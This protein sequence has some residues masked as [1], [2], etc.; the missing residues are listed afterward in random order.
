MKRKYEPRSNEMRKVIVKLN[1]NSGTLEQI[2]Q[3]TQVNRKSINSII[4]VQ[5][6]Q[7][8]TEKKKKVDNHNPTLIDNVK[9]LI[10]DLQA[11]DSTLRLKDIQAALDITIIP[12]PPSLSTIWRV[13]QA[14]GFTTKNSPHMSPT[15]IHLKQKQKERNG[16]IKLV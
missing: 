15:V 3:L 10:T 1:E 14:A 2:E 11:A 13:L 16:L 6:K 7:H 5:H 8:R 12:S 4:Q 9:K